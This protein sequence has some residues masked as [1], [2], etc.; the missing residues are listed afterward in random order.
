ME[1]AFF[2]VDVRGILPILGE[3]WGIISAD[4]C[5]NQGHAGKIYRVSGRTHEMAVFESLDLMMFEE[6]LAG[7]D[8]QLFCLAR[9]WAY[10]PLRPDQ[11]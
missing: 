2:F 3:G 7:S 11:S 5:L 9:S 6:A 8:A 4:T 1:V 10:S